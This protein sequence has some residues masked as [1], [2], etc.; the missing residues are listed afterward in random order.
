MNKRYKYKPRY[1]NGFLT[2]EHGK[3]M[4]KTINGWK[5]WY[6]KN[7]NPPTKK[8]ELG[9]FTHHE[10]NWIRINWCSK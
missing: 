8:W 10:E 6:K 1:Q 3:V 2:N 7:F 4:V 5:R 9:V